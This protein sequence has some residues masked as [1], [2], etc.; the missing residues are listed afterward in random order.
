MKNKIKKIFTVI[1][2]TI[3]LMSTLPL[4]SFATFITEINSNAKFGVISN[5]LSNFG[6]E[7]HYANYDGQT[8]MAFCTEYGLASASG[9][10][11]VYNNE[12]K[13][14]FKSDIPQ[15]EKMS[16][17]I[18]FG[19]SMINGTG[20]P[21]GMFSQKAACCTQQYVWEYI[22]NNIDASTT[23][24]SRDSW[25]SSYMSSS[26]YSEWLAK[27]EGYYNQYNSNVSFN[28]TSSE[29]DIG[30]EMIITDTQD[31]LKNYDTF[32]KEVNGVIFYHD[33]GSNDLKVVATTRANSGTVTFDS[34][35]QGVYETLPGYHRYS[36]STMSNYVYFKFTSGSVQNLIFSNYVD[37][38]KISFNISIKVNSGKIIINK[39]NNQGNPISGCNFE[40]YSDSSCTEKVTNGTSNSNGQVSFDKLKPGTYFVKETS[41][42]TGYLIDNTVKKVTVTSGNTT[43]V[44]FTNQEPTGKIIIYKVNNRGDKVGGAVFSIIANENIKNKAGTKTFYTKGQEVTKITSASG[45]G[46]AQIDNLPLGNYII[47]EVQAPTGYLLNETTYTANLRYKDSETSV[48]QVK[49]EGV[50]NQEPTGTISIIKQDSETGEIP[51]GDA[52]FENAKYEIY[53]EEDIYNVAKTKKYY[54]KGDLV[55]T[56]KIDKNGFTQDITNLPLGKYIIK[57][58]EAPTGY[59]LDTQEYT[60]NLKYKDQ[61]TKVITS[62]VTSKENVKKMQVHIFKSGIKVNSGK[63]PGLEGTEFTIKLNSD[64]EKAFEQGYTYEEVWKGIDEYGNQVTVDENRVNEAQVIARDYAVITTDSDGNAY[65]EENLPYGKYIVKETFTPQDYE[66]AVDFTF[67]ITHDESEIDKAAKKSIHITVNNEQLESYVKLIKKD[68]KTE[69]TVT[70]TSSTFQIKAAED[71]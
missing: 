57:E 46:I 69:K 9:Q 35:S 42:P 43:T 44:D 29:I 52:T 25:D 23:V 51:Q 65:T 61:N 53:A 38:S 31:V 8:Y 14:K 60:V 48:V 62:S 45:T 21:T 63:T 5:S 24:P 47:K 10:D 41:V 58:V 64:V 50:V 67:S 18:Y 6:H 19:Y 15:Y 36:S 30:S 16:E 11:Y 1:M 33:Q 54:S 17:M 3:L 39:T 34:K 26:I 27:T 37:V 22:H 28:G 32:E 68:K 40:L 7:L 55:T 71:I 2:L 12:F 59:M 13:T 56:R 66:T 20:V 70:L 49:I 4:N